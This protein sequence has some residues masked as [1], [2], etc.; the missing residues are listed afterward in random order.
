MGDG[1]GSGPARALPPRLY[2]FFMR[3]CGISDRTL[4]PV[5][6]DRRQLNRRSWIMLDFIYLAIAV[7]FFVLMAVYARAVSKG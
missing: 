4:I 2:A 5:R 7:G 3:R 1:G 6:L